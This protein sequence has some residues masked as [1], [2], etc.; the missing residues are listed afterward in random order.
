V[1]GGCGGIGS[2]CAKRLAAES[3]DVVVVDLQPPP[4]GLPA[5]FVQADVRSSRATLGALE[6]ACARVDLLVNAPGIAERSRFGGLDP[7]EWDSV[8][9]VNVRAALFLAEGLAGRMPVGASV[10][11]VASVEAFTVFAPSGK[12]TP[13]YAST[14]AALRSLTET[15]AVELGPAGIRVNAVA[16]GLIRTP[17]SREIEANAGEWC[18][19]NIPLGRVGDVGDVADVVAFLA[20]DAARY[21]TGATVVVDG[22]LSLG[23]VNR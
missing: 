16:P 2:A 15:L 4:S 11:N 7:D 19:R 10:V 18:L 12:T 5:R 3:Y 13:I 20:S 21:V 6:Q 22:G 1:T 17:L 23:L 9:A 8:Y 14:K